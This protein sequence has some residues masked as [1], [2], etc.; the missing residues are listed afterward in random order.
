M[1]SYSLCGNETDLTPRLSKE[2]KKRKKEK[3]QFPIRSFT[4]SSE[5]I[6]KNNVGTVFVCMLGTLRVIKVEINKSLMFPRRNYNVNMFVHL[7]S[8]AIKEQFQ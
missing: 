2:K 8:H 3:I 7:P 1:E 6:Y 4:F 5:F